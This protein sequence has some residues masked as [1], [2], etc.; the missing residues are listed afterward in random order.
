MPC[1]CYLRFSVIVV[2]AVLLRLIIIWYSHIVNTR[3]II[4]I[5][6]VSATGQH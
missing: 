2:D 4:L 1:A 5:E 6:S 3:I